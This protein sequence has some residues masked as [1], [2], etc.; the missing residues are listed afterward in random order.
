MG[1]NSLEIFQN[2]RR[3]KWFRLFL[4]TVK[5]TPTP[6][7]FHKRTHGQFSGWSFGSDYQFTRFLKGK[8]PPHYAQGLVLEPRVYTAGVGFSAELGVV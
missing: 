6:Q 3:G 2:Q 7:K 8:Y 4:K 1:S 5:N